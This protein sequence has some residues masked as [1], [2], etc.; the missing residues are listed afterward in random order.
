ML[1][2]NLLEYYSLSLSMYLTRKLFLKKK[3]SFWKQKKFQGFF[4]L[5]ILTHI[6]KVSGKADSFFCMCICVKHTK[7]LALPKILQQHWR[8]HKC[9]WV[10]L[11]KSVVCVCVYVETLYLRALRNIWEWERVIAR[12]KRN[13]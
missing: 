6:F 2:S 12:E 13:F 9:S 1:D 3:H 10:A 5:Q 8:Q 7:A 4:V 11:L